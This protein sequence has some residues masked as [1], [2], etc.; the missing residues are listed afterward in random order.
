MVS[1]HLQQCLHILEQATSNCGPHAAR[2][3]LP[4]Q[5]SAAEVVEHLQRAYLAT[6][7]GLERC[8]ENGAP[9]ATPVSFKKRLQSFVLLELGYFPEGRQ[10]PKGVIPTGTFDM[11]AVL[12][13]ARKDL[14][15]LDAAALRARDRFGRVKVMDHPILGA[16]S[17]DQ[18]LRFHL[19]HT[20][21]HE[22]QIRERT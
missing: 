21:H 18:W 13:A 10:A 3:R 11:P 16:F 7:K 2:R 8:L 12:N 4:D 15:R 9:M 5:W 14:D 6:A 20:R 22:K 19:A 1:A 17:V